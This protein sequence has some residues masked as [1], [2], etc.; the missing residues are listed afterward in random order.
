MKLF[1]GVSV[2][3]PIWPATQSVVVLMCRVSVGGERRTTDLVWACYSYVK[4][5]VLLHGIHQHLFVLA[6]QILYTPK[7]H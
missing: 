2:S 5:Y 7:S 4:A 1:A 3:H 6:M